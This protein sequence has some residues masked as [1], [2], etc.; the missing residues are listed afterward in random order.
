MSVFLKYKKES[1]SA[2]GG[3]IQLKLSFGNIH[4]GDGVCT[5]DKFEM[6]LTDSLQ[7]I[8]KILVLMGVLRNVLKSPNFSQFLQRYGQISQPKDKKPKIFVALRSNIAILAIQQNDLKSFDDEFSEVCS[9]WKDGCIAFSSE[10]I[11]ISKYYLDGPD[12]KPYQKCK[13]ITLMH[14]RYFILSDRLSVIVIGYC[15]SFSAVMLIV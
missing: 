3:K 11:Q 13:V 2:F 14:F 9:T 1:K 7:K 10:H 12:S 5:R 8:I 15:K 4:V 6:L